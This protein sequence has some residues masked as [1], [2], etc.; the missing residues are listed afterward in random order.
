MSCWLL[1]LLYYVD[2]T[3]CPQH[4]D[5]TINHKKSPKSPKR[6]QHYIAYTPTHVNCHNSHQYCHDI[7]KLPG[8]WK[9]VVSR[10]MGIDIGGSVSKEKIAGWSAASRSSSSGQ[11]G[12]ATAAERWHILVLLWLLLMLWLTLTWLILVHDS[13]PHYSLMGQNSV[14]YF[15]GDKLSILCCVCCV[16]ML[17]NVMFPL[18]QDAIS[19][20][21][22][23]CLTIVVETLSPAKSHKNMAGSSR[24]KIGLTADKDPCTLPNPTD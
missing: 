13:W 5:E 17:K 4:G 14:L 24:K 6:H 18:C 22:R 15:L 23:L 16:F 3:R 2:F 1:F 11:V 19:L 8:L 12:R 20:M 21:V 9:M 7:R 10:K